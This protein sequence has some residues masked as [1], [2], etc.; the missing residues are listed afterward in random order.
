VLLA[1]LHHC[2]V[3]ACKCQRLAVA[4]VPFAPQRRRQ[5]VGWQALRLIL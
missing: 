4:P 3:N 1:R 2:N 5:A